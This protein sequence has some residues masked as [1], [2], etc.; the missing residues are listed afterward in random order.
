MLLLS[1]QVVMTLSEFGS[2][3][4]ASGTT[5]GSGNRHKSWKNVIGV[6]ANHEHDPSELVP[7]TF[8]LRH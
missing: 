2:G 3:T 4:V 5:T 6:G 1:Q 7:V 8:N